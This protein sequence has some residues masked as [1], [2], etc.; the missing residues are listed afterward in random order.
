[1]FSRATLIAGFLVMLCGE[2]G[3]WPATLVGPLLRDARRLVP[4]SLALLIS[5]REKEI[6]E[7]AQR[8]PPAL[9]QALAEDI[10]SG[11]LA[12]ETLSALDARAS[13]VVALF[14]DR[15]VS[16]GVVM[17]GAT[18]RIPADLSDPVL[19]AGREGYPAG[20]AREY[21]AFVEAS[22]DK[23]PVVVDDTLPLQ[24]ERRD[25]H[26][27]WRQLLQKSRDQAA[28]IRTEMYQRGSV[29]DHRTIDYRSPVFGVA[30]LAYSRAV[31][32]IAATWLA[33]WR[34]AGG[35]MTRIR[36]PREILPRDGGP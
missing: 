7:E 36:P 14:K 22:L 17:L 34:E 24:L 26:G 18:L 5:E 15:R 33:L 28:I 27:Y 20:V 29:V 31:T 11:D 9:A 4:R 16:E 8:L 19:A 1:M 10:P 12:P 6:S 30:Q 25:L 23:M 21:Y 13:E 35:D 2:A 3:A 32:G